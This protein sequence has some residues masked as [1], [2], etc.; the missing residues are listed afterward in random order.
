MRKKES[1]YRMYMLRQK[2]VPYLFLAPNL[3]I[4]TVYIIIPAIIGVYY[5]FTKFDGLHDPKF[6]GFANYVE[7]FTD[8]P[9]FLKALWNTI[10]YVFASVPLTYVLALALAMVIIQEIK[11]KGFFRASYY[12]PVM[13]SFIVVG[14]MWQWIFGD[15]FGIFNLILEKS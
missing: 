11:G 4:F 7:L 1:S 8:D 15:Q 2:S 10:R 3:I 13:I 5:S 12:W 6:I 14:V 9:D